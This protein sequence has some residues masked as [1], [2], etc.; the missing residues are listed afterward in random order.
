VRAPSP[1]L[2]F[3]AF[4][5]EKARLLHKVLA[6]DRPHLPRGR[7]Q[8]SEAVVQHL[9]VDTPPLMVAPGVETDPAAVMVGGATPVAAKVTGS[10]DFAAF[11]CDVAAIAC[12]ALPTRVVKVF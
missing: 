1:A 5:P 12:V 6:D 7:V 8:I 2:N 3:K 9:R 10:D 4:V 11:Y